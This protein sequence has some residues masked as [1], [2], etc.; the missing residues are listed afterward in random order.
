MSP[1]DHEE[2]LFQADVKA[3]KQWWA[4]SRWRYTKRPFT[5]EQIVAKRGSLKIDYPS[6]V[7]SRKLWQIVESRFRASSL[8]SSILVS[9]DRSERMVTRA[10][11]MAAWNR[12]C[13]R[14][15]R[16]ISIPS[17]SPVGNAPLR[18]HRPT[19][20]HLILPTIPW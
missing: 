8:T 1:L 9:V 7:Q 4:D 6:N 12:R 19:N 5:A 18:P 17:M 20:H 14:R 10:L 16:N 3:V 13:L 11:P 15:W 2:Q